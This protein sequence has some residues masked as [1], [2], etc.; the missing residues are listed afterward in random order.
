MLNTLRFVQGGVASKDFVPELMHYRI[1]NNTIRSYN[2]MIGLQSPIALDLIAAPKAVPFLK[3]IQTCKDTVQLHM[4][5]AG[6]LA[7]KSGKFKAFVE[8]CL[9]SL[10]EMTPEGEVVPLNGGLRE[11]LKLLA[12]FIAE[13][14]SRPWS[15]GILFRGGSAFATNNICLIECWS[16]VHV[17][18]EI[19]IPRA[20][21]MEMIR[22][23]EDPEKMQVT[24]D[25]VTFFYSGDRWLSTQT[26][27]LE[28]PDLARVLNQPSEQLPLP[29]GLFEAVTDLSPFVDELGRIF[30]REGVI[31][32]SQTD[33]IGA[34]VD[35][36]AMISAEGCYH[37]K[38]LLLLEKNIKTA[39]FSTYPRPCLFQG[40]RLR[41]A[42]VGMRVE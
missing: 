30:F 21:V 42:I 27:P 37:F 15:R 3:A 8:C 41:G 25:R 26:Y 14:A 39:D 17:P 18:V 33:G 23:G 19:N 38:Q 5:P 28:W 1:E 16:G 24:K 2:G 31:S 13:D 6:K 35:L 9:E 11:V 12:P 22:I 4:T 29:E 36:S 20:A 32:T 7:I 40:D 10:P 34:S